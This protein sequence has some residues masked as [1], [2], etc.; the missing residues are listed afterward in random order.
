MAH[1]A[2]SL[3]FEREEVCPYSDLE[4]MI[5]VEDANAIDY[6]KKIVQILE[7]QFNKSYPVLISQTIPG[8]ALDTSQPF[9]NKQWT[10]M[11]L[12]AILTRPGDGRASNYAVHN[13]NQLCKRSNLLHRQ[14]HLFF[15]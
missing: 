4:F 14:R 7:I 10:W 8:V 1:S 15:S 12:A 13:Q 11:L 2:I 6:F 9:D 5:L 3:S